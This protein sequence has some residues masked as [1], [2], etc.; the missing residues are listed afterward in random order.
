MA[1]S[2]A[3]R[4]A[5]LLASLIAIGA[6]AAPA[7][8]QVGDTAQLRRQM[9]ASGGAQQALERLRA[10]GMTRAQMR[11]QLQMAGYDPNLADPYYDALE[12]RTSG[13]P[14]GDDAQFLRALDEMDVAEPDSAVTP[15][16]TDQLMEAELWRAELRFRSD[17]LYRARLQRQDSLALARAGITESGLP[18]FGRDMFARLTTEFE[19]VTTGPVDA[20]YRLG[21]GDEVDLILTGDVELAYRLDVTREGYLVIPDVGQVSVNGLTLG[22][23]E[24]RLYDRLGQ[25]YSGVRR[26]PEATTRFQVSLGSLRANQVYVTGEAERPS[27]YVLSAT[28]TPFN[29][30]YRAGGPAITGSF[31]NIEVRRGGSIVATVDLYGYLMEGRTAQDVRLNNGDMVFV[32]LAG[33]RVVVQ[34]QVRR[35]AVYEVRA[36]EGLRDVL[37]FAGGF[38]PQAVVERV[39][40]ERILPPEQRQPGLDR[41]VLDISIEELMATGRAIAIR[42]GDVVTVFAISEERRRLVTVSG[43]VNRPGPYEWVP[44]MTLADLLSRA[45]GVEPS[46]YEGRVH[47][48]RLDETD[49][50]RSLLRVP[51]DA[52]AAGA[53][54]LADRD[55]VVIYSRAVL[56]R[57]R[58]V[59][60][61]GLV[62]QPGTYTL[63]E[64]MTLQDLVLAAGGYRHGAYELEAEVAR[65]PDPLNRTDTTAVTV[66]VPL[67]GSSRAGGDGAGLPAWTPAADEVSLRHGDVVYIR[68]APGYE[69]PRV[70]M[71]TGEVA[72]P[73]PY[74]LESRDERLASLIRR[75][76]GLTDE[77]YAPGARLVR[78]GQLVG[79][80][81]ERA[82]EDSDARDNVQLQAGDSLYVPDY[83]PTVLVTGAV[84][85]ETRA[86]YEPGRG[87]DHYIAQAGGYVEAADKDRV[88]VTY[89]NGERRVVDKVLFWRLSPSIRPGSV[90]SVPM[91]PPGNAFQWDVL[92]TR[93]VAVVSATATLLIAYDRI[94][95]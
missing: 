45:Q 52:G 57:P 42:D 26:G 33:P 53:V 76:G 6:A 79:T 25:V 71:V 83:D 85:F 86:L 95:E 82:L 62:K 15:S 18:L 23:L 44:G 77:A 5:L 38:R 27:A 68:R 12:G 56:S 19:P 4:S 28:A 34:G 10:S 70:V 63:A 47:I 9:E 51:L 17:S 89:P 93:T 50:S 14:G 21:P 30:L 92:L 59:R 40:V 80:D 66:Q 55:S 64:G 75:A 32:P 61:E 72:F 48:F 35:P 8:S 11:A 13:L 84:A 54:A 2:A 7:A 88:A 87:L 36:G 60:I 3:R 69:E 73:G 74:T 81:L 94:T 22:M 20:D 41:V 43:E 78:G 90:I 67:S 31:R 39:H 29:A 91:E 37:A 24:E 49:M 1:G 65:R 46:A 16:Q 58:Q